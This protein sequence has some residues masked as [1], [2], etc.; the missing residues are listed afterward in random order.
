MD[1]EIDYKPPNRKG[2]RH[3]KDCLHDEPGVTICTCNPIRPEPKSSFSQIPWFEEEVKEHTRK[4]IKAVFPFMPR[5]ERKEL[6]ETIT[7]KYTQEQTDLIG[8][9]PTMK[10]YA[11]F[12]VIPNGNLTVRLFDGPSYIPSHSERIEL[13]KKFQKKMPSRTTHKIVGISNPLP[14][15]YGYG[16]AYVYPVRITPQPPPPPPPPPPTE[17]RIE[18]LSPAKTL[19]DLLDTSQRRSVSDYDNPYGDPYY[20]DITGY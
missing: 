3:H 18:I 5:K 6:Q 10:K 9:I 2:V 15:Q 7:E 20:G 19:E 12:A 14:S 8:A 16:G 11:V 4:L 13:V 17:D 1:P